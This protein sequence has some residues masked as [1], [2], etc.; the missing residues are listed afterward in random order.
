MSQRLDQPGRTAPVATACV[1]ENRPDWSRMVLAQA[2]SIRNFGGSLA[3]SSVQ[4]HF[5]GGLAGEPR[6][7]LEELGVEVIAVDPFPSPIPHANK[8]R[9]FEHHADHGDGA[10]I[11]LDTDVVIFGDLAEE[12]NPDALRGL[13]GGYSPLSEDQW[14]AWLEERQLPRPPGAYHMHRVGVS[15]SVPYLDSGVL[16]VPKRFCAPLVDS[17]ARQVLA[18]VEEFDRSGEDAA[19]SQGLL[20]A[21]ARFFTD[22]LALTCALLETQTPVD[23]LP[24]GCNFRPGL[25]QLGL[26]GVGYLTPVKAMHYHKWGLDSDGFLKPSHFGPLNADIDRLNRM[27][28]VRRRSAYPSA[29]STRPVALREVA[30]R[31]Y[32]QGF[33]R[34]KKASRHSRHMV[35]DGL[36]RLRRVGPPGRGEA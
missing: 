31:G 33:V 15:L 16:I 10:L 21:E 13:T 11:A 12:V 14:A 32:R 24:V 28:A 20:P 19:P 3:A 1:S 18:L 5:V 22:Q 9:M 23:P 7:A 34:A 4:A 30:R 2:V 6:G 25:M 8:L 27:V 26:S 36:A 17:W 29:L 35:L